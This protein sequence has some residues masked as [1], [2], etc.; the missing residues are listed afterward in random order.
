MKIVTTFDDH[1]QSSRLGL[2]VVSFTSTPF[3]LI[4]RN[5]VERMATE[6]SLEL[7]KSEGTFP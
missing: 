3:D 6:F 1:A 2:F 5:T 4:H 7:R